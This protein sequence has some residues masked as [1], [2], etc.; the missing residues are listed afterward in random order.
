M[1]RKAYLSWW[2]IDILSVNIDY[3]FAQMAHIL[4]YASETVIGLVHE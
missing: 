2:C 4:E 3:Y 1:A